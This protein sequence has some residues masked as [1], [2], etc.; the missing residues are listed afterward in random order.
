MNRE[1]ILLVEDDRVAQEAT[2][3]HL[4]Q[5][6]FDVVCVGTGEEAIRAVESRK[7]QLVLLDLMLPGMDGTEVCRQIKANPETREIPIVMLTSKDSEAEIVSGLEMGAD[8]YV[9]KPFSP[10]VLLARVHAVLRRPDPLPSE[11]HA[12]PAIHVGPLTID[13][14]RH[15]VEVK[16][17]EI[18]LTGTE[19]KILHLLA[20]SPGR[21]Y[22]RQSI[23]EHVRGDSYSVTVR[24][25][26]VQMVSLRKKLGP[27]GDWIETVRGVGYRF[28]EA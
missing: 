20:E 8:D 6:N 24:I 13:F 16:G 14:E 7:P 28:K 11:T 17:K 19:F 22:P 5:D 9:T 27:L 12:L 15:K 3:F 2:A 1:T 21:A 23:V 25:V 26:D 18:H 10:R 4:E